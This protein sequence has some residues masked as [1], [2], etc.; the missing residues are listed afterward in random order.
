[1]IEVDR[2]DTKFHMHDMI[3]RLEFVEIRDTVAQSR[4]DL[5]KVPVEVERSTSSGGQFGGVA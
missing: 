4:F 5:V 1:M 3:C 2:P